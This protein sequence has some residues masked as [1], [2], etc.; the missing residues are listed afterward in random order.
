MAPPSREELLSM[1]RQRLSPRRVLHTLG[2]ESVAACMAMRWGAD[3]DSA[4]CAAL[5][6]DVTKEDPDQLLLMR[7]Y[8]I[9][10]SEWEKTAA[11]IYHA[12]TGAALARELG[13]SEKIVSAVRFHGTGRPEMTTLEKTIFLADITEPCRHE[14]PGLRQLRALLH[15]SL[16]DALAMGLSMTLRYVRE[17]GWPEDRHTGEALQWIKER[18]VSNGI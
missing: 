5:L 2:V 10:P 6:H 15:T 16:D 9:L 18:M 1:L 8:G 7:N 12:L 17:N 4:R 11:T 3:V 13:F 14:M